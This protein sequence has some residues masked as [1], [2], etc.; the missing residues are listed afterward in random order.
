[1]EITMLGIKYVVFLALEV[2]VFAA[3]G[4]V[5]IAGLYQ[6][7]RNKIRESRRLDEVAPQTRPAASTASAVTRHS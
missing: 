6:I 1:M 2:F 4:A 7:V 3:M 5:L